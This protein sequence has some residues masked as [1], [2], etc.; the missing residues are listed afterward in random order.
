M[1]NKI[2]KEYVLELSKSDLKD[3]NEHSDRTP[4]EN[5]LNSIKN[6]NNQDIDILHEGKRDTTGLGAPDFIINHA[7]KCTNA[8]LI[9]MKMARL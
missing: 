7:Q 9:T 2:F 4:L 5:L 3:K 8:E 1:Q 6:I